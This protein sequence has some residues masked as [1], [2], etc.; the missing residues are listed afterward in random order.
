MQVLAATTGPGKEQHCQ[1]G[2]YGF[3]LVFLFPVHLHQY[4]SERGSAIPETNVPE[5]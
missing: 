2:E 3:V 1:L 4:C 5:W